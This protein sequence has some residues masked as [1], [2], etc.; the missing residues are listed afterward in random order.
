MKLGSNSKRDYTQLP[1][2]DWQARAE[3]ADDLDALPAD[4][5][6][7]APK[8]EFGSLTSKEESTEEPARAEDCS[9]VIGAGSVWQG[10]F[11]TEGSVRLEGRVKGEV[12]AA[13]TVHITEGAEVNA[14]VNGKFIV[15]AGSFD[16]QLFCSDRV[17]LQPTSK[18]RGSITT[19]SFSVG[20]GAFID[21]EIHM[22][23]ELPAQATARASSSTRSND[24]LFEDLSATTEATAEESRVTNGKSSQRTRA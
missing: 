24:A 3:E 15:I 8:Y 14:T 20:E 2:N 17:V 18:V 1:R 22:V 10:N 9:S 16:G 13:G 19:R 6:T 23:D 21:G 4:A 11:S 12:K 7:A 5:T